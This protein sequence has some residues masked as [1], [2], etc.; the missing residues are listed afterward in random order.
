MKRFRTRP[1]V[2]FAFLLPVLLGCGDDTHAPPG[3]A[4]SDTPQ[5]IKTK[6]GA[7]MV[8]I[9]AGTFAMGSRDGEADEAP[10]HTV[11]LDAFLMDRCEVTQDLFRKLDFPDPSSNK[12][13][14]CPVEMVD[15]GAAARFCNE[16]SEAEGLEPCYDL[17]AE[18]PTCN[19]QANGY[20]LPTE[21]EWEYACRA[22]TATPYPFGRDAQRLG[23]H[24]WFADNAARKSHPVGLKRPNAWGLFDMHGNVAEWCN[25]VYAKAYYAASPPK[26]PRGPADGP[27]RVLRGGGWKSSAGMCRSA[28]RVEGNPGLQDACFAQDEIGFRCVRKAP[29]RLAN[30]GG[31]RETPRPPTGLVYDKL[32]LEHDTGRGFPESPKRLLAITRRLAESGLTARLSA[33]KRTVDASRWIETIHD[34]AYVARVKKSCEQAVPFID[35]RDAPVSP[36]SHAAAVAAVEGVL[37]A[38]DAVVA[39]KVRNA[40]CAIRPPGHHALRAKAMGFCLFNNVA[41]AARYI[42][43][44]HKLARVLIVDWDVHHGN[45]TQDAFYDDPTV[46]YFSIHQYPFYP[47]TGASVEKGEGKGLGFTV[48]APVPAGSGDAAFL[49]AFREKLRP[50]ADRFKPHFVLISA[51]FD[52]HEDD[53]L[54]GCRVTA[55]GFGQLTAIVKAIAD[56]HCKGRLV[57]MLEGGYSMTGL[58]DSVEAHVRVLMGS[59][60]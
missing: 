42:Q 12:D 28:F 17:E 31:T 56:A 30:L 2:L 55:K 52:A 16:R 23:E 13:P 3:P 7:E 36:K 27:Y 47:G 11:A 26:N 15:F 48:N 34:P 58:A 44:K 35:T 18:P 59:G 53:P 51:G 21:A 45:G 50:A 40:F 5:V 8:L 24:A 14:R 41:I 6:L 38:V 39:G 43:Q 60:R 4:A 29:A 20:R 19:V 49:K 54:G 37:S 32:Y 25:D 46:L 1:H 57:S 9:P 22:G 33:I 10:V